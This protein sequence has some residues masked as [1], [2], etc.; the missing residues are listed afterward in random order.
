MIPDLVAEVEYA[1]DPNALGVTS[2]LEDLVAFLESV[3][4]NWLH[5][6]P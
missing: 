4:Q 5:L 2:I 3:G 1:D 6:D